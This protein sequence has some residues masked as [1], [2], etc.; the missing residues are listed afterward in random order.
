MLSTLEEEEVRAAAASMLL[1]GET[2]SVAPGPPPGP[3]PPSPPLRGLLPQSL[4]TR[5]VLSCATG[6]YP[7]RAYQLD[8]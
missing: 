6:R 5:C 3:S 1:S 8:H 7:C 2:A 4:P